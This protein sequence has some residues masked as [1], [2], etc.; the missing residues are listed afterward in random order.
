MNIDDLTEDQMASFVGSKPP[1]WTRWALDLIG[2]RPGVDDLE[3]LFHRHRSRESRSGRDADMTAR[4]DLAWLVDN[5]PLHDLLLTSRKP[6]SEPVRGTVAGPR[7]PLN[8]ALL[9]ETH[10]A[11]QRFAGWVQIALED[12]LTDDQ[13]PKPTLYDHISWL[14]A[15]ADLLLEHEAGEEFAAEVHDLRKQIQRTIEGA[16]LRLVCPRAGCDWPVHPQADGAYYQCEAGHIIDHHAEIERMGKIQSAT[17]DELEAMLAIPGSTL[18]RWAKHGL[19]HS[20]GT[21]A[22]SRTF[23][24]TQVAQVAQKMRQERNTT[25]G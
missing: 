7:A 25:N 2:Y 10:E 24:I 3:I 16:P 12:G 19:I 5:L 23:T 1:E 6:G 17:I 20:D 13:P 14:A 22:G 18:H 8:I 9:S 15:H 11:L 21:R 4:A